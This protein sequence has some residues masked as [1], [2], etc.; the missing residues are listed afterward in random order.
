MLQVPSN[1]V[2]EHVRYSIDSQWIQASDVSKTNASVSFDILNLVNERAYQISA[3]LLNS[4]L[5]PVREYGVVVE[6]PTG[7]LS[8]PSFT[9]IPLD[10][11]VRIDN[12]AFAQ[13]ARVDGL[14]YSLDGIT[15]SNSQNPTTAFTISNLI[16]EQLYDISLRG[17]NRGVVGQS[18][19]VQQAPAGAPSAP[20]ILSVEPGVHTVAVKY[21]FEPDTILTGVQYEIDDSGAWHDVVHDLS[22]GEFELHP[23]RQNVQY[24]I[25]IRGRNRT[26]FGAASLASSFWIGSAPHVHLIAGD[27]SLTIEATFRHVY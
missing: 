21:A 19:T 3:L 25:K 5:V 1:L 14:Q 15:W 9:T 17:I 12:I 20:Q 26:V 23:E 16:N 22:T 13:H 7:V 18:T 8:A 2:Y 24:A 6:S 27:G 4:Q 10:S 11:A